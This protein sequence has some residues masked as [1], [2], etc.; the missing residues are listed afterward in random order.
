MT[1]PNQALLSFKVKNGCGLDWIKTTILGLLSAVIVC[2]ASGEG[3]GSTNDAQAVEFY[4]R[5]MKSLHERGFTNITET[6]LHND[7]NIWMTNAFAV[8][9]ALPQ[10]ITEWPP[11]D[12]ATN[13]MVA[14]L[15]FVNKH[16]WNM[17]K[18]SLSVLAR[19][20]WSDITGL[21]WKPIAQS[22]Y[23]AVTREGV[24]YVLLVAFG[25][26]GG[27]IAWNPKTNRFDR[28]ISHFKP[29]GAGWYSW[30]L[31]TPHPPEDRKYEGEN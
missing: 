15:N 10:R 28:V 9:A 29:L 8:H 12:I 21:P 27:G 7:I 2:C 30:G 13:N 31:G 23:Q 20:H 3:N 26:E 16:G 25:G 14:V 11:P 22:K 4:G 24:L 5:M 1:T 17:Q 18:E 6:D 19:G